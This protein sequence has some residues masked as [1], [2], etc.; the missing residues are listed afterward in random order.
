MNANRPIDLNEI[1]QTWE[2]LNE[3]GT[4]LKRSRDTCE[5]DDNNSGLFMEDVSVYPE[6]LL[7][8]EIRDPLEKPK[9]ERQ[10]GVKPIDTEELV[11][12]KKIF[13]VLLKPLEDEMFIPNAELEQID[14]DLET[15]YNTP[16]AYP[17]DGPRPTRE[18]GAHEEEEIILYVKPED[19]ECVKDNTYK[20]EMIEKYSEILKISESE[21][22][23]LLRR[24][25]YCGTGEMEFGD[26]YCS[27]RCQDYH[28][29]YNYPCYWNQERWENNEASNCKMCNWNDCYK[30]PNYFTG[31]TSFP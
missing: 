16:V 5:R 26:S 7:E 10:D 4:P 28:F 24:C 3:E 31:N 21:A 23:E 19:Y 6:D 25:H 8:E 18:N 9:L 2:I 12:I 15:A 22:F 27:A 1:V 11:K 29:D 17:D 20:K 30:N 13:E 14:E